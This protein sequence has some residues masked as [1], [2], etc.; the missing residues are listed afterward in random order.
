[1]S[2]VMLGWKCTWR[3]NKS[4]KRAVRQEMIS[5]DGLEMDDFLFVD[6][7]TDKLMDECSTI[8][9]IPLTFRYN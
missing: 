4:I 1:M 5:T 8:I 6:P 7:I 2:E 9:S 3:K